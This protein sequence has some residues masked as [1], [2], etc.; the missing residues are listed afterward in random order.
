MA[1]VHPAVPEMPPPAST[2]V[3]RGFALMVGRMSAEERYKGHDE[4]IAAWPAVK[5]AYPAACLVI[6]GDGTD[7]RRLEQKVTDAGLAADI[8]FVGRVSD[9]ELGALYGAARF[10]VMPSRD[11]G[12]GLVYLEA[13]QLGVPCVASPGAASEIIDDGDDGLLVPAGDVTAIA[14]ACV[15]MFTD[16]ALCRRLGDAAAASIARRFAFSRFATE[17]RAAIEGR[18]AA[19]C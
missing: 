17:L 19:A 3:P 12:F 6:A 15:R 1:I 4:V 14:A 18:E 8:Q 16:A 9:E 5:A 11:E 7:R 10:F 2:T 13:M